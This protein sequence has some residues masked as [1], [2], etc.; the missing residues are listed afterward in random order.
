MKNIYDGLITLNDKGEATVEMPGWFEVL[1]SDYRYQLT[2]IGQAAP[3][4]HIIEEIKERK[5]KIAGGLVGQKVSWQVTGIR[6]D[7]WAKA[8]RI[9]LEENKTGAEKGKLKLMFRRMMSR[10]NG[11]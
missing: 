4:L 5:F 2:S 1:N 11:Q 3:N 7:A 9:P 6:K 8:N 10:G